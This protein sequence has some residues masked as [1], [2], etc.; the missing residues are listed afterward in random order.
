RAEKVQRVVN[1]IPDLE[2]IGDKNADL[3]LVG[4][5]STLGSMRAAI[6]AVN[7]AGKKVAMINIRYL[8]PLP[9]NLGNILR[10][11]KKVGVVE[12][13]LGQLNTIIRSKFLIDTSFLGRVT[14]Q[15][16]Y[17]SELTNFINRELESLKE[18]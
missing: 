13:N 1:D 11:F 10:K 8:N 12:L 16:I 2:I 17:V 3:L 18:H 9:R 4:W 7:G 14:G 6:E 15:P 5:G